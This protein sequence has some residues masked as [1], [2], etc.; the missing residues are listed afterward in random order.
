[1]A[2]LT[3]TPFEWQ[4]MNIFWDMEEATVRQIAD[5]LPPAYQRAYTTIQTYVERLTDKKMLTK[6]RDGKVNRYRIS[7]P[8]QKLLKSETNSMV[9]RLFN[10]SFSNMAA[11][12][13]RNG[14]LTETD[15]ENLKRIIDGQKEG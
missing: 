15:I 2:S 10:G 13:A 11:Y 8:R 3:L 6:S 12:L 9:E 5:A 14:K 1:M 7:V 4:I